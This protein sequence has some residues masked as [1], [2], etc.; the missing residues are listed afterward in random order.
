MKEQCA[1]L[2]IFPFCAGL[3]ELCGGL[4]KAALTSVTVDRENLEMRCDARFSRMPAPVEIGKL[5]DALTTEYG[6]NAVHITAD[7]PQPEAKK[8]REVRRR[9]AGALRPCGE[10]QAVGDFL[11]DD[12]EWKRH[13][14]RQSFRR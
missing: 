2:D 8:N 4:D 7:Y 6:L 9:R 13:R 5:E 14:L 1:F 3:G 10:G 12:G 11:P